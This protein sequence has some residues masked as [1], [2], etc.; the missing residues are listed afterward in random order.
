MTTSSP[1]FLL[2]TTKLIY[3]ASIQL[4]ILINCGPWWTTGLI[5]VAR[6]WSCLRWHMVRN[7]SVDMKLYRSS[8]QAGDRLAIKF[9]Q[10][11]F[12]HTS[13]PSLYSQPFDELYQQINTMS[14]S[15]VQTFYFL[16]DC[17]PSIE[18]VV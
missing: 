2:F 17:K 12:V 5:N 11:I 14:L 8:Y 1:A 9:D 13:L 15:H 7:P 4:V 16:I 6:L 18:I 3:S 10:M